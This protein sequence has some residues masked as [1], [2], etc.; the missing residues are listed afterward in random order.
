M[1]WYLKCLNQYADFSGR[2][3]RTEYWMFT[4]FNMIF[5][6]LTLF[7]GALLGTALFGASGTIIGSMGLYVLYLIAIFI[8]GLSVFVRRLHDTENSGWMFFILLIPL[9]G[10]IWVFVLM[11]MDS[12]PGENKWGPNPKGII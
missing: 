10:S 8:P 7:I 2:A 9:I 11:I 6:L 4:L 12:K 5:T 1:K 3:R